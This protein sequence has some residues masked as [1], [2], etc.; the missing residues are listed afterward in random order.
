M[1]DSRYRF[2]FAAI[3]AGLLTPYL[4]VMAFYTV[5]PPAFMYA[6]FF[7]LPLYITGV[8]LVWISKQRTVFKV[9]PTVLPWPILLFSAFTWG[10]VVL[11][12]APGLGAPR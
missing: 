9:L 7:G 8:V 1:R 4:S 5:L 2:G 12:T 11:F 10:I 3:A 6:F